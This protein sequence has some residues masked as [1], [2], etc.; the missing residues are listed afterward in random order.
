M[1]RPDLSNPEACAAYRREL[2]GL[3]QGRGLFGFLL[4][5]SGLGMILWPVF[6]EPLT[7]GPLPVQY[8]GWCQVIIGGIVLAFVVVGRTRYNRRRMSEPD[9]QNV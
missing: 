8:W 3:Y 5:Q 6:R 7:L 4:A 9:D 1:N 2:R